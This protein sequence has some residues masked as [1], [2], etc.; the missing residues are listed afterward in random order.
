MVRTLIVVVALA[1]AGCSEV[2]PWECEDSSECVRDEEQG[3]CTSYFYCAYPDDTC[4]GSMLRYD[5]TAGDDLEDVCVGN[6]EL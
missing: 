4:A 2:T 5:D 3:T 1:L 6:E